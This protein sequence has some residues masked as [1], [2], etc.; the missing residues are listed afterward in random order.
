MIDVQISGWHAQFALSVSLTAMRTRQAEQASFDT[1][2]RAQIPQR[3]QDWAMNAACEMTSANTSCSL[4]L[5]W[6]NKKSC[7][8][9]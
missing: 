7:K 3:L 1:T 8:C 5:I 2:P 4:R 6:P 9:H